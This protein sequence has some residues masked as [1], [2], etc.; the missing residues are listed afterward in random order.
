MKILILIC[1]SIVFTSCGDLF[2]RRTNITGKYYIFKSESSL[3]NSLFFR[4]ENGD[5][6]GRIDEEIN[7]YYYTDSFLATKTI[8]HN[9]NYYC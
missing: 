4:I 1:I 7:E 8:V 6:I 2:L 5:Y 3:H 9:I